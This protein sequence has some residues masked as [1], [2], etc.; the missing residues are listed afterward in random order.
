M[1]ADTT[2]AWG[3]V[4]EE[5]G[6]LNLSKGKHT[7]RL[8]ASDHRIDLFADWLLVKHETVAATPF[9]KGLPH[10]KR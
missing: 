3:K 9:W 2:L 4:T 7:I 6:P 5:P 10:T 1:G 8:T